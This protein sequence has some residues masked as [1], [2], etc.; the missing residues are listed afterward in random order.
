MNGDK[1]AFED[2]DSTLGGSHM[3]GRIALV[4]GSEKTVDGQLGMDA[5]EVAP[6]VALLLGIRGRDVT[7]PL[8]RGLLQGWRGKLAFEALQGALPGGAEIRP[9]SGVVKSDGQSLSID[10]IKGNIGGGQLT[11]D[12]DVKPALT[13]YA[14][15]ARI[16]L[17][18][19]DGSALR[20]RSLALPAG[21]TSLHMT[22]SSQGRSASAL[23]GA[24]SGSGLLNI[25]SAR[26]PG[27]DP[28]AFDIAIRA[29]DSGQATD[30][31]KLRQIVEPA[32]SAGAL[33]V[34]SMQIPFGIKDSRLRVD[35]TT[36]DG[37]GG[38][39]IVSGGYDMV[40]DQADL[41]ATLS[42]KT[43]G[44]SK[45]R[46]ELQIFA[47]GTPD[48]LTR[49][50]DVASL[51]SW[52]AVR[53]ID[54]E[55]R[56][57]DALER[58]DLPQTVMPVAIPPAIAV[59]AVAPP[60]P[61]ID[62][63]TTSAPSQSDVPLPGLDPRRTPAKASVPRPSTAPTNVRPPVI[64]QQIAPLPA[65]IEVRPA[66]GAARIARPRPAAPLVLTPQTLAPQTSTP[67]RPAF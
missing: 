2:I 64:S 35:A 39:V 20:Y 52:L 38:R 9:V 56:R 18:N 54:R 34:A 41:R 17:S 13:G 7:E 44:L 23:Q 32:L 61:P 55:T 59:P 46:P 3:R 25:D 67:Q 33:S 42:A 27:L 50:V 30:D 62:V 8:G 31:A 28:Q 66:P 57:L 36:I 26:I 1:L 60:Q 15:G 51:S 19:A 63:P 48:Q 45:V 5:I 37:N 40:A 4:M 21:K 10:G 58:G 65:P 6:A 11:A 53:A 29:S 43:A 47:T 22:L 49:T 12:M 14:L 24:V 16:Q